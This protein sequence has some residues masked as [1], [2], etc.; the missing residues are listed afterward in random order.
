MSRRSMARRLERLE[1]REV[2]VGSD[3]LGERDRVLHRELRAGADR[4]MRSMQGVA[5]QNDVVGGLALEDDVAQ[6]ALDDVHVVRR[7]AVDAGRVRLISGQIV[8]VAAGLLLRSFSHLL[9]TDIAISWLRGVERARQRV[10]TAAREGLG[11]SY[12]SL[13]ELYELCMKDSTQ[14][15]AA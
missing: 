8:L 3:R 9:D 6:V 14:G 1:G 7:D 11:I 10:R 15:L 13:A 2:R 4:E 12:V 5:E